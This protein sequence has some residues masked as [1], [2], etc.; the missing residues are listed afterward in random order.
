[1]DCP[2]NAEFV[3]YYKKGLISAVSFLETE[4]FVLLAELI[5][6]AR[7]SNGTIYILGNGGSASIA[8]HFAHN[9]NWDASAKLEDQKKLKALAL[10]E[11]L[12][13]L[14]GLAN[15][16]HYDQIFVE[17][18]R[19]FLRK[20]DIVIGISASGNADNVFNALKYAK[21]RKNFTISLSGNDGGKIAKVA[22]LPLVVP[23]FD[24]QIIEDVMQTICHITVRTIFY[25]EFG[26]IE[27]HLMF[28]D[29]A[30][31]REKDAYLRYR[32]FK[33]KECLSKGKG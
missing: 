19:N 23:S 7:D 13:H 12:C 25:K 20:N 1:M 9:L 5:L 16:R 31:L 14:T 3:D 26:F 28:A 11:N 32:N 33:E 18:L 17:Q 21:E 29:I 15:D 2:K 8:A 4:K 24:Q 30:I 10:H 22:N 6:K 27:N